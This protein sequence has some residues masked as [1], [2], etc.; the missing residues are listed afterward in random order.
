MLGM[1]QLNV[2]YRL[3][4]CQEVQ[5]LPVNSPAAG[6]KSAA[7]RELG[8]PFCSSPSFVLWLGILCQVTANFCKVPSI[9]DFLSSGKSNC[10]GLN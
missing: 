7:S 8:I 9:Q 5:V 10:C 2:C 4:S 6:K 3:Q 1:L